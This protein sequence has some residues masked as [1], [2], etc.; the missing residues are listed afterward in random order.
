M[1]AA[2]VSLFSYRARILFK[3]FCWEKRADGLGLTIPAGKFDKTKDKNIKDTAIRETLEETGINLSSVRS[4]VTYLR[5]S[6]SCYDRIDR[7][8]GKVKEGGQNTVAISVIYEIGIFEQSV[9][10]RFIEKEKKDCELKNLKFY[11]FEELIEA[12]QSGKKIFPPT[13]VTI[14]EVFDTEVLDYAFD[15][16]E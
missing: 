11:S 14:N 8:T 13:L 6:V 3:E 2:P 16:M 15:K 7:N 10:D 5:S 4:Q 1:C 9:L 12:I